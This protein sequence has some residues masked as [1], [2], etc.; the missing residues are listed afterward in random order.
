[1][2][3]ESSIFGSKMLE[4][5]DTIIIDDQSLVYFQSSTKEQLD[6]TIESSLTPI[7]YSSSED[8]RVNHTLVIDPSQ[9]ASQ[10]DSNTQYILTIDLKTILSNYIFATLKRWRTFEGVRNDMT[11]NGDIDFAMREYILKNVID[12]YKLNGVELYLKYID[13]QSQNILKFD[14]LWA[15]YSNEYRTSSLP[16]DIGTSQYQLKKFQSQTEF[17]YSST[18]ITFSQEKKSSEFCFDYFFKLFYEKI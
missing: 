10:R 3:E 1:M 11:K 16:A 15:G 9:S 5:D 14:N 13:I 6:L 18:V 12:R 17:D 2:K 8:K 4:I 7:S